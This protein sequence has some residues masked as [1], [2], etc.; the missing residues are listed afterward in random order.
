MTQKESGIMRE[1]DWPDLPP[2]S[3]EI[4]ARETLHVTAAAMG[5]ALLISGNLDAAMT[6]L[7]PGAPMLGQGGDIDSGIW[8]ARIARDRALLVGSAPWD[9]A[10][11]WHA[12]GYAVTQ[13]DDLW[14]AFLVTGDATARVIAEGTADPDA[15]SP[16]AA[17]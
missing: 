12:G 7:A 9:T 13:A 8:A 1:M 16:S 15:G 3:G 11:G 2:L 6:A 10:P 14:Q 17:V 5:G 4:I